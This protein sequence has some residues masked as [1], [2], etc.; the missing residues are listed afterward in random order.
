MIGRIDGDNA[1]RSD[2]FLSI[3]TKYE[4]IRKWRIPGAGR[5]NYKG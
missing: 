5:N 3:G 1:P 2:I 4:G